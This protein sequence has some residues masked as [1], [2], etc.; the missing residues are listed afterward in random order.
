MMRNQEVSRSGSNLMKH[1]SKI[2]LR[3]GTRRRSNPDLTTTKGFRMRAA[4]LVQSIHIRNQ[5]RPFISS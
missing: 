4:E 3:L 2:E 5:D 1:Q